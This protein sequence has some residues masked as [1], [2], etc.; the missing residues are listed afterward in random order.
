MKPVFDKGIVASLLRDLADRVEVAEQ[1]EYEFD[2]SN[3]TTH[4]IFLVARKYPSRI[5]IEMYD[6]E[7][8]FTDSK[9]FKS[10]ADAWN[11]GYET[12]YM[13]DTVKLHIDAEAPKISFKEGE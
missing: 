13:T 6:S 5:S 11:D 8:Q 3:N 9:G 7:K 4:E 1:G 2:L 10:I 12:L